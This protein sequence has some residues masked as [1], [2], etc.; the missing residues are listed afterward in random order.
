MEQ[1]DLCYP[2]GKRKLN[3]AIIRESLFQKFRVFFF[4]T[5]ESLFL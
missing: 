4:F 1:Y 5:R 2:R 3:K